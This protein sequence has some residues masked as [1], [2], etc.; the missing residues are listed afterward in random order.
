MV[1]YTEKTVIEEFA[2][3]DAIIL[4]KIKRF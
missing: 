4:S 3:T 1:F 2:E